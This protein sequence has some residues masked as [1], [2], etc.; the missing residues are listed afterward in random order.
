MKLTAATKAILAL[1]FGTT[2]AVVF[3]GRRRVYAVPGSLAA[4]AV[5]RRRVHL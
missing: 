3:L 5:G 1:A 4:L 2:S